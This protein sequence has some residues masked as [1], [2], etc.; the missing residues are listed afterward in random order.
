LHLSHKH[1]S[2]FDIIS[3]CADPFKSG[4]EHLRGA[5]QPAVPGEQD[6]ER[7]EGFA[8]MRALQRFPAGP[9]RLLRAGTSVQLAG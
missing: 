1:K 3:L 8:Q 5:K 6:H 9:A 2:S 4:A 7:G